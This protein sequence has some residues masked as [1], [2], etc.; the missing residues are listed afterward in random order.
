MPSRRRLVKALTALSIPMH[1]K[2][3]AWSHNLSIDTIASEIGI[4]CTI[5]IQLQGRGDYQSWSFQAFSRVGASRDSNFI[6]AKQSKQMSA[7]RAHGLKFMMHYNSSSLSM[8]CCTNNVALR[9]FL[10]DVQ[11]KMNETHTAKKSLG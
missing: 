6:T 3:N 1:Q 10:G 8:C 4:P 5:D 7:G 2:V 9:E 11:V